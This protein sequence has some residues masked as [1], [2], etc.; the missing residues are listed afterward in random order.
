MGGKASKGSTAGGKAGQAALAA[1]GKH[2]SPLKGLGRG[3]TSSGT[4]FERTD[5]GGP[6]SSA[7][8][9]SNVDTDFAFGRKRTKAPSPSAAGGDI[10]GSQRRLSESELLADTVDAGT[11][12][13]NGVSVQ[14]E[15]PDGEDAVAP[16]PSRLG[17]GSSRAGTGAPP[18][19]AARE[20][21]LSSAASPASP[22]AYGGSDAASLL[23]ISMAWS[24]DN[25]NDDVREQLEAFLLQYDPDALAPGGALESLTALLNER[26]ADALDTKLYGMY[27]TN[28]YE[29]AKTQWETGRPTLRGARKQNMIAQAAGESAEEGGNKPPIRKLSSNMERMGLAATLAEGVVAGVGSGRANLRHTTVM[30]NHAGAAP[31][32]ASVPPASMPPPAPIPAP[33]LAPKKDRA[34]ATNAGRSAQ[35]PGDDGCP[36]FTLDLQAAAFGACQHCGQVKGE[37]DRKEGSSIRRSLKGLYDKFAGKSKEEPVSEP[38][39]ASKQSSQ[40]SAGPAGAGPGQGLYDKFSKSAPKPTSSPDDISACPGYVL[41]LA[42]ATFGA[43]QHCGQ[44]KAEHEHKDGGSSMRRSLKD[45]YDKLRFTG[46]AK[47]SANAESAE[48]DE[49]RKAAGSPQSKPKP[50]AVAVAAATAGKAAGSPAKATGSPSLSKIAGSP[51]P[52]PGKAGTPKGVDHLI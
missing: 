11:S 48:V 8:G 1:G 35:P 24:A 52:P 36:G 34:S 40:V 25:S 45:L 44:G 2:G 27:G 19:V 5:S 6:V 10:S 15:E 18:P 31:A 51:P 39:S 41:D 43:C 9:Y 46:G 49:G 30:N 28:L 21:N 50:A 17:G 14:R 26:G 29:M 16:P 42:G 4:M 3:S 38:P 20:R 7:A 13:G 23:P 33:A 32:P 47:P 22:R 37:H 12:L